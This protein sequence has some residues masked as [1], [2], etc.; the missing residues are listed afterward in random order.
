MTQTSDQ[1]L[2]ILFLHDWHWGKGA[3]SQCQSFCASPWHCKCYLSRPGRQP[4]WTTWSVITIQPALSRVIVCSAPRWPIVFPSPVPALSLP[5][6]GMDPHLPIRPLLSPLN[7][8]WHQ[9]SILHHFT[10]QLF[11]SP[12]NADQLW[13]QGLQCPHQSSRFRVHGVGAVGDVGVESGVP[14]QA[15][16]ILK[17]RVRRRWIPF[18]VLTSQ[19]HHGPA[20]DRTGDVTCG[21]PWSHWGTGVEWYWLFTRQIWE[22]QVRSKSSCFCQG[23]T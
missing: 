3:S 1:R 8:Q 15:G 16:A 22:M 13:G 2:A 18:F 7:Q 10:F 6:L 14:Q 20:Q 21:N 17:P 12:P 4:A 9:P 23:L 19:F 11:L 5:S